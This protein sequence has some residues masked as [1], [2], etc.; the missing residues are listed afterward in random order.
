MKQA[1]DQYRPKGGKR[2]TNLNKT[3]KR[4]LALMP[5]EAR[6]RSAKLLLDAQQTFEACTEV[7]LK[8]LSSLQSREKD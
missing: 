6:A 7:R 2:V 1:P 8:T 5:S 3:F 4:M